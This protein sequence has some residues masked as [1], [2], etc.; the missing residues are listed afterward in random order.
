MAVRAL[1]HELNAYLCARL[2]AG[3]HE[4]IVIFL[5]PTYYSI[6]DCYV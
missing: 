3:A 6:D 5:A 4:L 2:I 1:F